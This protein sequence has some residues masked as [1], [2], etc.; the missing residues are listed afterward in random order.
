MNGIPSS[1]G[2]NALLGTVRDV[3]PFA[4][5]MLEDQLLPNL[6]TIA[7]QTA[8]VHILGVRLWIQIDS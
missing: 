1:G 2:P 3:A 5:E 7:L 8:P 6:P 4:I